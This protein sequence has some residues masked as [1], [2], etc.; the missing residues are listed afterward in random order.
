MNSSHSRNKQKIVSITLLSFILFSFFACKI[1]NKKEDKNLIL[2]V[3]DAMRAD[4]LG[5]YGYGRDTT[6]YIDRVAQNAAVCTKAYSQSNWTC[7]AMASLFSGTYPTVHKIY[8]SFESGQN[9]YSLLPENLTTIPEA[10]KQKDLY[11]AAVT[12]CGWV[13]PHSNY[14]QGFDEF[15]LVDRKDKTLIDKAIDIINTK[16]KK[17]FFLYIHLLELHDYYFM[18]KEHNKFLKSSY[19]LS[20]SLL[21][22]QPNKP[23]ENYKTLSRMSGQKEIVQEDLDYL[24][25]LY[26]SHLSYTDSLV[27]QLVQTLEK[28]KIL[29]KTIL[30]ITADHGESFFE[31]KHLMHGGNSLYNE[32]VRVPLIVHNRQLFPEHRQ[33]TDNVEMIDIFPTILDLFQLDDITVEHVNQIQGESLLGKKRNKVVFIENAGRNVNKI[34][35]SKWSFIFNKQGQKRELYDLEADPYEQTNLAEK[36]PKTTNTMHRL[37]VEKIEESLNLSQKIIPKDAEINEEVKKV[38]KSLG[39][40]K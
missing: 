19:D 26:D 2:L 4:H 38:L 7:T 25:D 1:G 6:P 3:V 8:N 36:D 13:S 24:I 31:H 27:G 22:L 40:I 35:Q 39:Y 9:R 23:A 10:L 5:V 21:Q 32:V 34:I 17:N 33:I 37:L 15:H 12:S 28:N 18:T 29:D 20:P 11:T 30:I 14:D 16:Q